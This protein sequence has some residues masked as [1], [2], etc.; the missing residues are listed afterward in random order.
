MISFTMDPVPP[1]NLDLTAAI[2]A[3]GDPQIRTFRDGSFRQA[4]AVN[5]IPA[6]IE[7]CSTGTTSRPKIRVT[8]HADQPIRR[9]L[10]E[11]IRSTVATLFS[12]E[13]DPALFYAAM[14]AD[15]TMAGL[16]R[17]LEGLRCPVTATVFEALVDSV[18]E[19]QISLTVSR[20][21]EN[22][23]IKAVGTPLESEGVLMYCYPTPEILAE[24]SD[25]VFRA[26]G[27]TRRKGEYIRDLSQNILD[28][29]LDL[30]SYRS[31][32]GTDTETIISELDKIRGIGRW[33]A[34]LA[35]L[36]GLHRPDAFP[37]DD[38]A[39]RRFISRF[40]RGGLKVL[41]DEARIFSERWGRFRGFA[42]YYLEVTELLRIMPGDIRP[43]RAPGI[44]T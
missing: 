12:T 8:C 21:I 23:L 39:V 17:K 19:Q 2:F 3:S 38:I 6:L 42:A 11:A 40:Y 32:P 29:T 16:T 33:T 44:V 1:F 41:P 14:A 4:L 7:V 13:D 15:E 24:V 34:E 25:P 27:L 35:V 43:D 5:G 10:K 26:C 37:A 18:I 31:D 30:E 36:R 28:G 20:G 9:D 22:R